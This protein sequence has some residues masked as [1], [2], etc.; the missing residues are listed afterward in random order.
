MT[1]IRT[2]RLHLTLLPEEFLDASVQGHWRR[3]AD[4]LGGQIPAEWWLEL[5]LIALRLADLRSDPLYAPWALRA[6]IHRETKVMV[7]FCGF[8]STPNPAYL[9]PRAANAVEF[10]YTVFPA[11]RNKG[12]ATEAARGLM[13]WAGAQPGVDRFVLSISESNAASLAVARKLGF[14][15]IG[16]HNDPVGGPEE[17]FLAEK[18][19]HPAGRLL[20]SVMTAVDARRRAAALLGQQRT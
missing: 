3:A 14:R 16:A 5:D 8:H 2:R 7:G 13:R 18:R 15:R 1:S 19:R 4:L 6:M 9:A 10:G 11:F 17:I 12:F 20:H